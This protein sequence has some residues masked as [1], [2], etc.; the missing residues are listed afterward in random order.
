MKSK[1]LSTSLQLADFEAMFVLIK[2]KN[3]YPDLGIAMDTAH[4]LLL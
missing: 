3:K 4:Y 2:Q 1:L